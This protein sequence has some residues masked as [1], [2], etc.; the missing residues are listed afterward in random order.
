MRP[1]ELSP[2]PAFSPQ[3]SRQSSENYSQ[4]RALSVTAGPSA[5]RHASAA[6][7]SALRQAGENDALWIDRVGP[8]RPVDEGEERVLVGLPLPPAPRLL[9]P[10]HPA[11]PPPPRPPTT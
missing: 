3:Y 11:P 10:P 1:R 7:V 2:S 6:T 5:G 4:N 8:S 9:P